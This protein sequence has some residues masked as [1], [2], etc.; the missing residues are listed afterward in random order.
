MAINTKERRRS[1]L[2]FGKGPRGTGMPIALGSIPVASRVHVL[3]LYS[4]LVPTPTPAYFWR[5]R[6]LVQ[7][8]W[9]SK[10][11]PPDSS[12]QEP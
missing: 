10:T 8:V 5:H 7:T 3:N 4:G 6:G 9:R 1:A 11:P 2:D 12:T